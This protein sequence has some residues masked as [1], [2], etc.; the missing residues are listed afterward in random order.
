VESSIVDPKRGR[1]NIVFDERSRPA[2]AVLW[3]A[4]YDAGYTPLS[5]RI[6]DSK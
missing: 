6:V 5:V 1:I 4:V 3:N 2:G